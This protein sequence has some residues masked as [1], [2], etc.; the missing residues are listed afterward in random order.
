MQIC[1]YFYTPLFVII[2]IMILEFLGSG[3]VYEA[4]H[5]GFLPRNDY[6]FFEL[7]LKVSLCGALS[8]GAAFSGPA[9]SI[10]TRTPLSVLTNFLLP[11]PL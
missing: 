4:I 11:T 6:R 7:F 10:Q 9:T 3:P 8:L 5:D 1:Q 2:T